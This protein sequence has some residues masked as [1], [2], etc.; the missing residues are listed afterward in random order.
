MNGTIAQNEPVDTFIQG[1][2]V[3]IDDKSISATTK[4]R[5][6]CFACGS[7]FEGST[8]SCGNSTFLSVGIRG[9]YWRRRDDDA[10]SGT[11]Y[12][13]DNTI[14]SRKLTID[15]NP[16][17]N[18]FVIKE[19]EYDI[20]TVNNDRLIAHKHHLDAENF[21]SVLNE[22]VR[23]PE[24]DGMRI[25]LDRF[26]L[27]TYNKKNNSDYDISSYIIALKNL[28]DCIPNVENL[29]DELFYAIFDKFPTT[30]GKFTSL[31]EFY[32]RCDVPM[33][34]ADLYGILGVP[35][36]SSLSNIDKLHP[37]IIMAVQYALL[38]HHITYNALSFISSANID[39]LNDSC[40]EF[41]DY[42]RRNALKFGSKIY[43]AYLY[44]KEEGTTNIK[45]ANMSKFT[46]YLRTKKF[47]ENKIC[48]FA[49]KM[50]SGD[51]IAALKALV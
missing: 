37:T 42:F 36:C 43:D 10:F 17:K 25:L 6:I 33:A 26:P 46:G 2:A 13:K 31:A 22:Y 27:D 38:H 24:W 41:A 29:S 8:C 51:A 44:V 12:I 23:R 21:T 7:V 11:C 30:S 49:K 40:Y 3:Y 34:L 50:E 20:L 4:S 5:N 39:V 15:W 47:K 1:L 9:R 28:Y 45:D 16:A 18:A 35:D 32:K 48:D 19:L 14:V